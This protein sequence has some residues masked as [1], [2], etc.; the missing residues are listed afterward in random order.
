MELPQEDNPN[1]LTLLLVEDNLADIRLTQRAFKKI[2]SSVILETVQDG[3]AAM[4]YLRE[5]GVYAGKPKPDLIL[6]DL[7]LPKKSGKE[8]LADLKNDEQLKH[9]PVV[10]LTTSQ[11]RDD[12]NTCYQAHVNCYVT[13][14][15]DLREFS[16]MIETLEYYW[17]HLVKLPNR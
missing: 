16:K 3:E 12:I 10:M 15:M 13:K 11:S 6:L 2:N 5:E 8:V 4:S 1:P 9:I 7:N 17:F 14:P